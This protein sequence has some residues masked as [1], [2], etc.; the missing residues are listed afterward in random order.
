MQIE[1]MEIE[2]MVQQPNAYAGQS[3][4]ITNIYHLLGYSVIII[5]L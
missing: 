3:F 1:I 2:G 4:H 5:Y